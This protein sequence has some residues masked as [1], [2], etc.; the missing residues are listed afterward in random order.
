M[1]LFVGTFMA[2]AAVFFVL[3]PLLTGDGGAPAESPG[4]RPRPLDERLQALNALNEIELDRATGK[5]SD[6]DY[7]LLVSAYTKAAAEAMQEGNGV[8]CERCGP[9]PEANARFCSSCGRPIP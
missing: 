5:L 1:A 3:Y 6:E 2:L 7:S 4:S 8:V 9:R